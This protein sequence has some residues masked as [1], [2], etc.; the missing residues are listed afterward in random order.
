MQTSAI[1]DDAIRRESVSGKLTW[2]SL[3]RMTGRRP[4]PATVPARWTKALDLGSEAIA[5]ATDMKAKDARAAMSGHAPAIASATRLYLH[6]LEIAQTRG[7]QETLTRLAELWKALDSL[8]PGLQGLA[9]A[10]KELEGD[11]EGAPGDWTPE[12]EMVS[13]PPRSLLGILTAGVE[14]SQREKILGDLVEVADGSQV[15]DKLREMV[16]AAAGRAQRERRPNELEQQSYV[17]R[18]AVVWKV[19]TGKRITHPGSNRKKKGEEEKTAR[20]TPSGRFLDA[21]FVLLPKRLRPGVGAIRAITS[22]GA[23]AER[24]AEIPPALS[25]RSPSHK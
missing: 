18:L 7:R 17:R 14:A 25:R 24:A 21:C 22:E 16:H 23:R 11:V 3:N 5:A 4:A 8:A 2:E 9:R 6:E 20:P 15:V 10:V 1:S 19:L 12:L 13:P